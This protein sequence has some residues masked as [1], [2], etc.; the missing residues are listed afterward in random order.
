MEDTGISMKKRKPYFILNHIPKCA[1]SS[2]R[3]AIF[4]DCTTNTE[5]H[6]YGNVLYISTITHGNINIEN[7]GIECLSKQTRVFVDHSRYGFVEEKFNIKPETAYRCLTIRNPID[8]IISHNNFFSQ[9]DV[10]QLLNDDQ[11]FKKL[12]AIC[13]NILSFYMREESVIERLNSYDFIFDASHQQQSIDRFNSENPYR[14]NLENIYTNKTSEDTK[15]TY[16]V[17][18]IN[19][20][21][22]SIPYEIEIYH[23]IR[24]IK[25]YE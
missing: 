4:T 24:R 3:K 18:L 19:K 9:I 16:P 1:G 2:L 5:N 10:D 20:I 25:G 23:K 21:T 8:R 11:S 22:Q 13:G 14:F 17:E 7:H 12:I 15:K 6:F